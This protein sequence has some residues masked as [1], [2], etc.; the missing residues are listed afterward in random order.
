MPSNLVSL[1]PGP[2]RENG[3]QN[4]VTATQLSYQEV[5]FHIALF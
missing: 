5:T 4:K 1:H 3:E 2:Y